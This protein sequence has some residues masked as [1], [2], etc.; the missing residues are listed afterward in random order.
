[1]CE[2]Q[3]PRVLP[4]P[5]AISPAVPTLCPSCALNAT[6]PAGFSFTHFPGLGYVTRGRGLWGGK[7]RGKA[8]KWSC[9]LFQQC[10]PLGVRHATSLGIWMAMQRSGDDDDDDATV[11][12]HVKDKQ[13]DI[14]TT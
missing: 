8:G 3:I 7:G 10:A 4:F 1:M 5:V 14:L 9:I 2:S 13:V 11:L 6:Q 12:R